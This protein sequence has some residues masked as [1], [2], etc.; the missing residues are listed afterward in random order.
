MRALITGGTGFLGG[1]L[2]KSLLE[3]GIEVVCLN[4]REVQFSSSSSKIKCYVTD[5]S[6][7]DNLMNT[8]NQIEPCDLVFHFAAMLS[9]T[10][11]Q[12]NPADAITSYLNTNVTATAALLETAANWGC[13]IRFVFASSLPII[14]KPQVLPVTE[15]HRIEPQHPYL[16]S[17]YLG[18]LSCEFMRRLRGFPVT[19]LRITSPYGIGMQSHTVLPLFVRQAL[20]SKDIHIYGSGQ[21]R[22]NFIHVSDVVSA[23]MLAITNCKPGIYNV[24]GDCSISMLELATTVLATVKGMTNTTSQIILSGRPDLQEDYNWEIDIT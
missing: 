24:G 21:R 8:L 1:H 14:G 15:N 18:E 7:T 13:V 16:F 12:T 2:V 3:Q 6:V 23:A 4:R 22:Q 17:K 9:V 19:S 11:N 20:E 5:L 10:G